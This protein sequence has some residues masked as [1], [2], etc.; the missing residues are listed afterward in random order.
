MLSIFCVLTGQLYI[1]SGEMSIQVLSQFL[2]YF[3]LC[4]FCFC[5]GFSLVSVSGGY[6]LVV[7]QRPLLS[8]DFL[9]ADHRLWG[10]WVSVTASPGLYSAGLNSCGSG[11]QS[12]HGMWCL[13]DPRIKDVFPALAGRFFTTEPL[14][15]PH[16]LICLFSLSC[17]SSLYTLDPWTTQISPIWVHWSADSPPPPPQYMY[18]STKC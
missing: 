12:L 15:N 18:Y 5:K 1:I 17:S 9:A 4:W 16:F 14:G 13:P 11:A 6:S 8:V 7:V 2:F 10:T 3:W